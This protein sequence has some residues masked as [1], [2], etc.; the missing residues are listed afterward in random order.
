MVANKQRVFIEVFHR[1]EASIGKA[2]RERL[3]EAI[4]HWAILIT[5]KE[6][7]AKSS[8]ISFDV[9]NA[10]RLHPDRRENLNPNMDWWFRPR[11]NV[12]PFNTGTFLGA[13]MIGKL[14]EGTTIQE[15][16]NVLARVPIPQ[17]GH[18]PEQNCVILDA[19]RDH[20]IAQCWVCGR[21]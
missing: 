13:L 21:P 10:A 6:F 17:K 20:S 4:Y 16:E 8:C 7:T 19:S 14:P 18:E 1:D 5:P 12:N 2:N 3:G 15:A 9:T 11:Y